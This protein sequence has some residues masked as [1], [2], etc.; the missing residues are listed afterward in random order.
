VTGQKQKFPEPEDRW[1]SS[2][3]KRTMKNKNAKN[4]TPQKEHGVAPSQAAQEPQTNAV[5]TPNV[6]R[7][8]EPGGVQEGSC[9]GNTA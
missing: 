5:G 1:K 2:T 8:P 9:T 3:D 6:D 4:T 7:F